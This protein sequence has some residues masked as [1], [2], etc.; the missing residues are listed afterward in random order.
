MRY[1]TPLA[2]MFFSFSAHAVQFKNDSALPA[3]L[4]ELIA[5]RLTENCPLVN[6]VF[7]V[8]TRFKDEKVDQLLTDRFYTTELVG[9]YSFD[10][11]H[12][13][14][15]NIVIKTAEYDLTGERDDRFYFTSIMSDL[16]SV[17]K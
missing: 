15:V 12:P 8:T 2:I 13:S 11:T 10:N 16:Q 14:S 4:Q 17:C 6:G 5:D 3:Q 7:E 9:T 1:L